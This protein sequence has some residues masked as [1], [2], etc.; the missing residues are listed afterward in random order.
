MNLSSNI[1]VFLKAMEINEEFAGWESF[2]RPDGIF[3]AS[4]EI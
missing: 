1:E 2:D 4:K 3:G